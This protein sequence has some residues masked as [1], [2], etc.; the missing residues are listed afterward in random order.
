MSFK[1]KAIIF[2]L[3]L[4]FLI[5]IE[6][7]AATFGEY[8]PIDPS[9][10]GIKTYQWTFGKTGQFT[11]RI[12][13]YVTVP[14]ISGDI[15][16]V[17]LRISNSSDMSSFLAFNDGVTVK[18]L[19]FDDYYF[20]TD[21]SLTDHP[22][23]WSFNTLND[24]MIIYQEQSYIINK[25]DFSDCKTIGPQELLI[26]IQDVTVLEGNYQNAVIIWCLDLD[27]S[28]T[29]L[30][31][32][33]KESDLGITLPISSDTNGY[34]VTGFGISGFD[35]G[36]IAD[37]DIDASTGILE[38]LSELLSIKTPSIIANFV[39]DSTKGVIP[40][41]VSFTDKSTGDITDW[42]WDFGDDG[43]STE[44]NPTHI[45]TEEGLY[46]VTFA[47]SGPEGVD[48][49]IKTDYIAAY[50]ELLTLLTPND[51]EII[52]SGSGY[53]IEWDAPFIADN[54][55]LRLSTD[56]GKA[57]ET[58]G[59]G[60]TD[61]S[62]EWDVP[63]PTKNKTNC[64]IKVVGYDAS[65]AKV[66]ADTSDGTF[67]IAV[68]TITSPNGGEVVPSGDTYDI[69]WETNVTE[70]EVESVE[71]FYSR[72]GG[73]TWKLIE[74]ALIGN[75]GTYEWTVPAQKKN[76]KDCLVKVK[77]LDVSGNKVA[78]DKSDAPFTIAVLEVT[79]PNG[80][81]TL[82]SGDTHTITWTT[83]ETKA[84][85]AKV[86]LLYTKNGGETWIKIDALIGGDP[87]TY[88]W[89]VPSVNKVKTECR[90]KIQL[91]DA[92]GNIMGKATSDGYFTIFP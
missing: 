67:T 53:T 80:E 9:K 69:T 60:I 24:G 16:G 85:V 10:F 39:A 55:K 57:W 54:F 86:K 52:P 36:S 3:P 58:I 12:E 29:S 32:Q 2:I 42:L 71:L 11:H 64:L 87:G 23:A 77:A 78:V 13:G 51:G 7:F 40:L 25:N 4:F 14:Y 18:Y 5:S 34:A 44:Q 31:F 79:S 91:K 17:K 22:S 81:E 70:S 63:T 27:K 21:C 65:G 26:S 45:Y 73:T 50:K 48:T 47:V 84:E 35:T 66:G 56:N 72:D 6:A 68:L 92:E 28:F 38:E 15:S 8:F 89:T 90:V 62:Y 43:N 49:E 61:T 19:G 20:S 30:N 88:D 74:E 33:G 46:T 1:L 41:T 59:K 83:N 37:G 75:P 82:T 76:L